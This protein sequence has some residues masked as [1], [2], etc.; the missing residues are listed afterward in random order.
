[1]AIAFFP[2]LLLSLLPPF[3]HFFLLLL[4]LCLFLRCLIWTLTRSGGRPAQ[5][6][7]NGSVS[8]VVR[9]LGH[10]A[11]GRREREKELDRERA[12]KYRQTDRHIDRHTNRRIDR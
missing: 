2:S 8:F 1:M 12:K 11:R 4:L 10:H 3:T 9:L 5:F 6:G 7:S